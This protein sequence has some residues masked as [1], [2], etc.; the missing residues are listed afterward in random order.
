MPAVGQ[1]APFQGIPL[2]GA[3]DPRPAGNVGTPQT[4]NGLGGA[5]V[6]P[7]GR[8]GEKS[9]DGPQQTTVS[10]EKEFPPEIVVG[11]PAAV[12]IKVR[13][14]GASAARD[15]V[16]RDMVPEGTVFV[17]SQ[18][19]AQPN[20]RGEL[21][22]RIGTLEAGKSETLTVELMPQAEGELG[23]AASVVFRSEAG[24]RTIAV[25]PAL[26]IAVSAPKQVLDGDDLTLTVKIANPG[27]G[28]ATNVVLEEHVPAAMSHPGGSELE[29]DLGTL[30][31]GETRELDLILK[32]AH[33]GKVV[34][35]L[36]AHG[37]GNLRAEAKCEFEVLAP[38]LEIKLDGP[39]RRYLERPAVYT[40]TVANPG[41][42]AAK[43]VELIAR[44]PRGVKF[45]KADNEG[46]YDAAS[47]SVFW[48]LEELPAQER[49]AVTLTTLPVEQGEHRLKIEGKTK[50]G[51]A[52]SQEQAIQIDGVAAI[53]FEVA[54][55]ADPI[56]L[57]GETAYDV[58]IINQG[59][60]AATNV[61]LIAL[62]PPE[63]RF[64][65][66]EGATRYRQEAGRIVFEPLQSLPAKSETVYRIRAKGEK[67]GD[68]RLKVQLTTDD[69]RQ[70][71]TKE[72]STRVYA[73]E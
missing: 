19:P 45:V 5:Q 69:V 37:D 66:A 48:S 46:T 24:G 70:P 47:H 31:P 21:S 41:T 22:W 73:D 57:H 29:L 52:Q 34:N 39:A 62:L 61:Q 33:A 1:P 64:L 42:A 71:I 9:L 50:A 63:L 55:L 65:A 67:P 25:R 36:T 72:E 54:D 12:A 8:P 4:S 11:K 6:T 15:V 27:S 44:L 59:S 2:G 18:P 20:A 16:V 13:N 53:L 10:V 3:N 49:G 17:R 26:T 68:V 58:R 38:G 35:N 51:L 30:K 7:T 23:S 60:K 40:L 43:E 28:A 14:T 32:A 56:E